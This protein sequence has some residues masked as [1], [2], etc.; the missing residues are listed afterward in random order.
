MGT[1]VKPYQSEGSKKEQVQQMFDNIAHRYDFLNRFLS[2]GIDKGWRK[3]AIKMLEAYQPK[4]I[5]DVAT[6]TADFAIATLEINPEEVIGVDIS[7][8]MLDVGR[9]KITEKGITN[10]RLESGDSENLQFEDASFDA[11]IV[12]FGVRNFENLE[13]GLAEINRVLRPGGV[14][15]ILE[16]SKPKGLFGVI[17]SIYNKTLLPL[18]G[19]LFS[20]DNAAY[21]YLPESVA[22]FPEGDEFKQIMTS[23][24]YKNVTDRRLT[25]GICSIYTGLK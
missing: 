5:L 8:G 18:W 25:F 12:A 4:R 10:I 17:F 7:E 11:V 14:A 16:F 23:V 15:M 9:K 3:K 2:L 22:A 6:G 19:K 24:K 20:G 1:T 21:K 13:K